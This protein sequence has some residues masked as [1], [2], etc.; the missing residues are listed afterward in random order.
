MNRN[1]NLLRF[2]EKMFLENGNITRSMVSKQNVRDV[3]Q[4]RFRI[5]FFHSTIITMN[6]QELL[7]SYRT[8]D[9]LHN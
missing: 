4:R 2:R 6:V 5:V 7:D 3:F 9:K 8:V 1:A